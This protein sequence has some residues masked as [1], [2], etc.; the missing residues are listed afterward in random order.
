VGFID[1]Q[2]GEGARCPIGGGP[3]ALNPTRRCTGNHFTEQIYI[4]YNANGSILGKVKYGYEKIC[5]PKNGP[6]PCTACGLTH[7]GLKLSES[8]EWKRT[9]AQIPAKVTKLHPDELDEEVSSR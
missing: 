2:S 9:E 4:L 7:G 6:F 8:E 1:V 3:A 5:A